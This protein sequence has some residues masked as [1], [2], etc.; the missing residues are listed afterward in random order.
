VRLRWL[1]LKLGIDKVLIKNGKMTNYFVVDQQSAFYQSKIFSSVLEFVK[2]HPKSCVFVEK[3]RRLTLSFEG[4]YSIQRG[5]DIL[6][7]IG[8]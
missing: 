5:I 8:G 1:A 3:N 7:Q 4:I 6:G 2:N